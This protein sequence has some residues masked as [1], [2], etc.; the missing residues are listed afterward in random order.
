MKYLSPLHL[1]GLL[2]AVLP[3]RPQRALAQ[4]RYL[5]STP[6]A[7]GKKTK[8]YPD[9]DE[10]LQAALGSLEL[11]REALGRKDRGPAKKA[12]EKAETG[13]E[14][15]LKTNPTS[16]SSAEA[17]GRVYFYQGEAGDKDAY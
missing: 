16:R 5:G 12:L 7:E 2:F 1:L 9:V 13:L 17:L 15:A 11:A 4:P 14:Q 3:T 6:A 8:S 10:K